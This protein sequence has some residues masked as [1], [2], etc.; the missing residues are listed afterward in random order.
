MTAPKMTRTLTFSMRA[1]VTIAIMTLAVVRIAPLMEMM[2]VVAM[3]M[4]APRMAMMTTVVTIAPRMGMMTANKGGIFPGASGVGGE[5]H[6]AA[7]LV[8]IPGG[9]RTM[10]HTSAGS[11]IGILVVELMAKYARSVPPCA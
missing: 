7:G 1:M 10:V 9:A 8:Q 4:I 2:A 6:V 5:G 11:L 3:V